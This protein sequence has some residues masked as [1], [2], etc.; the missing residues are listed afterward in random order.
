MRTLGSET[1]FAESFLF[2]LK[3]YL[4]HKTITSQNVP[5]ETQVKNFLF[6][7]KVMFHSR[8]TQV[9]VSLTFP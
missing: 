6:R 9:F 5:C 4:P 1:I 3:G 8:Y 2:H 7:T